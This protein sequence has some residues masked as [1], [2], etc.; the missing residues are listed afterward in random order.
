ML[1]Q[2]ARVI[3]V[4]DDALALVERRRDGRRYY[5][6]PGG[7][8]EAGESPEEAAAREATEELG[9]TVAVGRRVAEFP[10]AGALHH[11]FLATPIGGRFGDGH[12]PEMRGEDPPELGTYRA[13]WL[14]LDDLLAL[15]VRPRAGARLIAGVR[16]AGWA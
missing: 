8:V 16:A 12:G 2:R 11:F 7:G 6:F 4:R 15:D 14:P 9:L 13:V 1:A 10:F 3:I 5:V